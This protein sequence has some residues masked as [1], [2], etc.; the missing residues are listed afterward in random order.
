M[1]NVGSVTLLGENFVR[2]KWMFGSLRVQGGVEIKMG[3]REFRLLT[4]M[5]IWGN[6]RL[7]GGWDDE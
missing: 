2:W 6:S 4:N 5:F 1:K 3:S 7:I